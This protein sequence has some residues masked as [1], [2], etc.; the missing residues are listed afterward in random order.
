MSHHASLPSGRL[1]IAAA[2]G[3]RWLRQTG[4]CLSQD[5]APK[6]PGSFSVLS[7]SSCL[8]PR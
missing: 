3:S 6:F 7:R 2:R 4:V 8:L 1:C 5:E